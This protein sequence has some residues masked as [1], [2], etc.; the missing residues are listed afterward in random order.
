MKSPNGKKSFQISNQVISHANNFIHLSLILNSVQ[1]LAILSLQIRLRTNLAMS[2]ITW[3]NKKI[4]EIINK[5]MNNSKTLR[6]AEK[7]KA[8]AKPGILLF[9]LKNNSKNWVI[10]RQNIRSRDEVT[11]TDLEL[12]FRTEESSRWDG[13]YFEIKGESTSIISEKEKKKK[14]SKNSWTSMRMTLFFPANFLPSLF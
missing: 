7:R 9:E 2:T 4:R 12:L 8:I 13:G 6:L 14:N 1:I 10:R 3:G 11:A 5:K